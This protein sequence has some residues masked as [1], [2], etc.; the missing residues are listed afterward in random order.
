M[1]GYTLNKSGAGRAFTL[2]IVT[3][4]AASTIAAASAAEYPTKPIRLVVPAV[5]GG[6]ADAIAR[7]LGQKLTESWGQQIVVENRSGAGGRHY[8]A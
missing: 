7:P 6:I 2:S 1:R 8:F 4:W 3:V 5:A